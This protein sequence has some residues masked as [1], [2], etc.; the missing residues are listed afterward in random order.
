M[1]VSPMIATRGESH[2]FVGK[3]IV[4][5]QFFHGEFI[6]LIMSMFLELSIPSY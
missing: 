1:M 2:N 3:A 5:I 4:F 6:F